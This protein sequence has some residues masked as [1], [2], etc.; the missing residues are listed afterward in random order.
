MPVLRATPDIESPG[1]PVTESWKSPAVKALANVL[2]PCSVTVIFA[3]ARLTSVSGER[4]TVA[5]APSIVTDAD[6]SLAADAPS[7]F[8]A[9]TWNS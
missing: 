6:A 1:T 2:A 9:R 5:A 3:P 4:L 8:F 7:E